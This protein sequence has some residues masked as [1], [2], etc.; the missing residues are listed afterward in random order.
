M[1]FAWVNGDGRYDVLLADLPRLPGPASAAGARRG[2]SAGTNAAGRRGRHAIPPRG[3]RLAAQVGRS[4]PEP[5]GL[6]TQARSGNEAP[7]GLAR[8]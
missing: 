1:G 7:A 4:M 3:L 2:R 8:E 5:G 6:V